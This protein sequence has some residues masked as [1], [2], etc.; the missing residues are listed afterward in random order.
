MIPKVFNF[1]CCHPNYRYNQILQK[2]KY[3]VANKPSA[4][5][6]KFDFEF[7]QS[8]YENVAQHEIEESSAKFLGKFGLDVET[9]EHN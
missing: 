1:A 5:M 8:K 7:H 4:H 2:D 3:E 9:R 6:L